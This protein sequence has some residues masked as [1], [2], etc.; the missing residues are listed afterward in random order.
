VVLIFPS[1]TY[2]LGFFQRF[3]WDFVQIAENRRSLHY[4]RDDNFLGASLVRFSLVHFLLK[5]ILK[6]CFFSSL[7]SLDFPSYCK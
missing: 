4:G 1:F 7:F 2:R 5:C 3:P 6:S